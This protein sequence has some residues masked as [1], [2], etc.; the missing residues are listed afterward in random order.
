MDQFGR[1]PND[2]QN[3]IKNLYQSPIMSLNV[4]DNIIQLMI[5]YPHFT[6]T[7]PLLKS[8]EHVVLSDNGVPIKEFYNVVP[9]QYNRLISFIDLLEKDKR[10]CYGEG[11]INIAVTDYISIYYKGMTID[12]S[13]ENKETLLNIF[14]KIKDIMAL[15][16]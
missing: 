6:C 3:Y 14:K 16:G 10:S 7:I 12:M 5:T 1:L 9:A 11:K 4:H 8:S 2:V 15:E 13:L